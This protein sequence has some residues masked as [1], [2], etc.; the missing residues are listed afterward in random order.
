MCTVGWVYG[1][2][3]VCIK[4][5][6]CITVCTVGTNRFVLLYVIVYAHYIVF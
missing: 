2:K 6:H 5:V 3:S 1:V 4:G